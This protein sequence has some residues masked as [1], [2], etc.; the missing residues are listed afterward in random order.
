MITSPLLLALIFIVCLC[1]SDLNHCCGDAAPLND[2]INISRIEEIVQTK[3]TKKELHAANN[4]VEKDRTMDIHRPLLDCK[5]IS[6]LEIV[7]IIG[8]GKK[9][10]TYEVNLP[11]GDQ[12]VLK[13]CK[14]KM[15]AY[16]K[17]TEIEGAYL[18]ALLH[19]QYGS[20]AVA[21]YGECN[22]PYHP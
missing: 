2:N 17:S 18:R 1:Y 15:C 4:K 19:K 8:E 12:A 22:L 21:F 11:W 7:G 20:Q 9:K 5:D 16:R 6:N 3:P 10:I 14:T 13:R